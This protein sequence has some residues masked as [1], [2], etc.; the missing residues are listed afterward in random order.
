MGRIRIDPSEVMDPA[1]KPSELVCEEA[2]FPEVPPVA[3]DQQGRCGT[4][5]ASVTSAELGEAVGDLG[6]PAG[7]SETLGKQRERAN[8][9]SAGEKRGDLDQVVAESEDSGPSHDSLERV[10]EPEETRRMFTHRPANVPEDDEVGSSGRPV[11]ASEFHPLP[12]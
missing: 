1:P 2:R 3:H 9:R 6:A 7:R 11:P 4:K 12:P 5:L 8:V 10:H